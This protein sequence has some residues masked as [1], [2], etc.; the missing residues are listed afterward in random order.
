MVHRPFSEQ[1]AR[2]PFPT[3]RETILHI[4]RGRRE[5]GL[6]IMRAALQAVD[7][8]QAVLKHV[9]RDGKV[10][11]VGGRPYALDRG[12]VIVTGAGKAGAAMAAAVE[13]VLGDYLSDGAVVVKEGHTA[14]AARITVHEAGHPIPDEAGVAGTA[15]VLS[16][17]QNLSADDLVLC[18]L[19]GGGSALLVQPV[20]GVGLE[21]LRMTND[22][23][24]RSGATIQE[25][26]AV[27]KHLSRVKGG[28]LTQA[29]SPAR[30][31]A[32][33]LSDVVGNAL[34]VIASGPTVPDPTTFAEAVGVL[35]RY[36]L[37]DR[38]PP[39]VRE[40]LMRGV[41]GEIAETLKPGDPQLDAVQTVI[42]GS[43]EIAAEAARTQARAE[44]FNA[45]LLSTFVEGEAREVAKVLAAIAREVCHSGR[46][47]PAPA[48]LIAGGE[49]TVTVRGAGSG[50]RNQELALAAAVQ[51]AGLEQVIIASLATDGTDGPTDAAGALADG[52]TVARAAKAGLK[53]RDFLDRNDAY[54]FFEA[55]G[56]LLVTGPTR[57]NVNDLMFAFVFAPPDR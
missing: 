22:L 19:S 45:L 30:V 21:D 57:T 6:R 24:L 42:I 46:P 40:C 50:G 31:V 3:F 55:L 11:F 12:R 32:L 33:V 4:D 43:N 27:R 10:L 34:D 53:A 23:L 20:G 29:A 8:R 5:P 38:V 47:V 39:S 54:R 9:R 2:L 18:L 49:T 14:P 1:V 44:G 41:R 17:L 13:E 35:R 48:C 15:D 36:A 37:L 26:N 7:P 51:I 56:D 28:R 16:R 25:I 52:S